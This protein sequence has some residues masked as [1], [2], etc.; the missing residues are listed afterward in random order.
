MNIDRAP[1]LAPTLL[2]A[3][4]LALRLPNL[5]Q[6]AHFD[7]LYHVLAASAWLAEGKL[8][9]AEGYYDR[10]ALFT[11]LVAIFFAL[12]GESLV[13]ARLPS[14]VAGIG[15]VVSV[16]WWT[17]SVAGAAAAWVAGL[18]VCISPEGIDASQF[19]RFYALQTLLCWLGAIGVYELVIRPPDTLRMRILLLAGVFAAFALALHLQPITWIALASVALWAV[20]ASA[21]PLLRAR[22]PDWRLLVGFSG[23]LVVA[24]VAALLILQTPLGDAALGMY[25]ATPLWLASNRGVFWYYHSHIV[26]YYPVLWPLTAIAVL[27]GLAHRPQPVGFCTCVFAIGFLTLSFAGPKVPRYIYYAMPFLFV[28]WSVALVSVWPRLRQ[29][30]EHCVRR[31]FLIQPA[32]AQ[33][34]VIWS[35]ICLALAW[36]IITNRAALQAVA[37]GVGVN[38]ATR[39]A[40]ADWTTAQKELASW[41]AEADVVLTTEELMALYY[42]G[43]YDILVSKSRL[44]EIG[45][46]HEFSVDGRTGRRVIS[47][48]GS[49]QLI[50]DCFSDG[51]IVSG[52]WHWRNAAEL[53]DAVANLIAARATRLDL[54]ARGIVAYAWR[55]SDDAAR[56]ARCDRLSDLAGRN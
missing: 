20:A 43:Q 4:A 48:P 36:A 2:A 50:L 40:E 44:S 37:Q 10:A 53:E 11:K 33:R 35:S 16:F 30:L 14:L 26:D 9:I 5:D 21:L 47:T 41:L 6:G 23:L 32:R 8:Q 38:I 19:A 17:R 39:Q 49:V 22:S 54:K 46:G 15:L 52:E 24:G 55:R 1:W 31:T 28:L 45:N 34:V 56:P 13:V 3:F 25:R 12:F 27:V 29:F 7:E 51:L 18:L 42:L